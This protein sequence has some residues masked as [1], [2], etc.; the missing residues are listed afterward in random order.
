MI[1]LSLA[2]EALGL[3][4][5]LDWEIEEG[6]QRHDLSEKK[7]SDET[8]GKEVTIEVENSDDEEMVSLRD[9]IEGSDSAVT[10]KDV[11]KRS[12]FKKSRDGA[13]MFDQKEAYRQKKEEG[14][15]DGDYVYSVGWQGV[16]WRGGLIVDML[17]EWDKGHKQQVFGAE[18]DWRS[19]SLAGSSIVKLRKVSSTT[20]FTKGILNEIGYTIKD[21]PEVNV[22]FIN[23]TLTSMQLK[24]L[25]KRWNDILADNDDR[26][27]R[28]YLKSANKGEIS[29]TELE[30]ETELSALE[31]SKEDRDALFD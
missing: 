16:Y 27:R 30:S 7:D 20:F 15:K 19:E 28:F 5:S 12:A 9:E 3:V 22:I 8:D 29:P 4:K 10:R 17:E 11:Y 23:S 6:P 25:E 2:S 14:I 1:E 31:M 24:K 26:M 21:K 13:Y 18:D